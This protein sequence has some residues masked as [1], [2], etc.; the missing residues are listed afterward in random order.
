MTPT[1]TWRPA[2]TFDD[3]EIIRHLRNAGRQW[4]ADTAHITQDDQ[5]AWWR[6]ACELPARDF[7]CRIASTVRP[8]ALPGSGPIPDLIDSAV[9]YGILA[10]RDGR[11]W[12]SLVVD[13]G[14]RGLGFGTEI[15]RLLARE[16][17]G[18]PVYAAIHRGNVRSRRAA[19]RAGYVL[20]LDVVAPV[21]DCLRPTDWPV[22]RG[23]MR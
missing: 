2:R 21:P 18:E 3:A 12:V 10:R 14:A 1:M 7:V 16:L 15:Y 4:M 22:L 8:A 19:E 17:A 23:G 5:R 13:P 6:E 11:M 20:D 9:G